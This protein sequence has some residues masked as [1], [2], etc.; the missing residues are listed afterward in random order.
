MD[1]QLIESVLSDNQK[2]GVKQERTYT[3]VY[4]DI[5]RHS[6][7]NKTELLVYIALLSHANKSGHCWP[8][9]KTIA[10]EAR[11]SKQGVIDSINHLVQRG[12]IR[13]ETRRNPRHK[14][15]VGYV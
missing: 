4:D 7:L 1:L 6:D 13:K 12:Y 11:S 10:K 5:I 3:V 9:L 15:E 2:I 8:G 14:K